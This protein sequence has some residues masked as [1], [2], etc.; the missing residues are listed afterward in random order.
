MIKKISALI[1]A[2]TMTAAAF[3]GCADKDKKDSSSNTSSAASESAADSTAE[4]DTADSG[5]VPDPKLVIDGKEIDTSDLIMCTIDGHD[6]DFD[7]FRY[8]YYY[9]IN[10]YRNT[11][12][13]TLEDIKSTE[14]GFESLLESVV[15]M[16]KQEY[17]TYNICEEN[18][19]TLTDEDKAAIEE[20][21]QSNL[22]SSGSEEAFNKVLHDS[23]MTPELYREMLELAK[24]YEKAESELFTNEGVYATKKDDF[25]SIVNDPAEYACIRSI[26]I[27]YTCKAEISNS[28]TKSEY[29]GYS[30][31]E[32]KNAKDAAYYA[33]DDEG[34]E[35]AKAAAKELA[36]KVYASASD[37]EDFESLITEYNWDP[38]MESS[39]QG[40]YITPNTSFVQ[41][42]LDAAFS[43]AEGEISALIENEQYGWFILKR[44]PID[45]D[46]VE[47]NIDS[48]IVEYDL[49]S[50]QKIYEDIINGMDVTFSETYKSLTADSIT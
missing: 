42:Y 24:L 27:P 14:G 17:V 25:K 31:S 23:Y 10:Y 21:Y 45:M 37:G 35:T 12:G 49:P 19:I 38:G 16:L 5:S 50:R 33:L 13:A 8:Y 3:T 34:K 48:M 1:I 15:T 40:Y 20:M 4:T 6:V 9:T 39:P 11:Y 2:L 22:E 30:L 32:K 28:D 26:L 41:E 46:Y 43:L 44:M 36:D 18:S 7:T 29:E 47:E